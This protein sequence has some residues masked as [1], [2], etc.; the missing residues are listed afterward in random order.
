MND[1]IDFE[2][3]KYFYYLLIVPILVGLFLWVLFWKKQKQ[4]QFGAIEM[5]EKMSP[6]YSLIKQWTKFLLFAIGLIFITVALV[7]PKIGTSL[8]TE[9]REGVDI[10][11]AIDI[12]KSMLAEDIA[13]NRLNKTK[14]LVSQIINQ[15]KTDR[16]GIVAYA[17]SAFP[18]LPLTTDFGVA[19]MYMSSLNTSMV[20]SQGTALDDALT[21]ANTF[22]IKDKSK[23]KLI[24]MITDGEDHSENLDDA[25]QET[26]DNYIKI[27][28]IGVG[29]DKGGNIPLKKNG[30]I[31]GYK[32]DNQGQIV[33]TKLN[34][35][36]L[37]KIAKE[38]NG[39]YVNGATTRDVIKFVNN[40]LNNVEKNEFESKKTAHFQSQFQWFLFIGFLLI[41]IDA[42]LLEKKTTWLTN[43]N[44]FNEKK[45]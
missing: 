5:I 35:E 34:K 8:K 25:I 12:S 37:E 36:I 28:T 26:K 3:T 31:E 39:A 17:G 30:V 20:S 40:A 41:F 45:N 43:L 9:K 42:F 33:V 44:L 29:T 2:E 4:K 27:V 10:V 1:I 32:K 6:D 23:N 14:Q 16:I 21:I 19:K 11:F 22:F 7:N 13:P 15:L 38:T 24:I 18:V